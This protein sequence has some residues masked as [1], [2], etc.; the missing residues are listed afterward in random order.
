VKQ[1]P[2][3]NSL[4]SDVSAPDLMDFYPDD[5]IKEYPE[6]EIDPIKPPKVQTMKAAMYVTNNPIN[7][8]FKW[9]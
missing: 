7:N 2:R 8:Y 5:L 4:K 9:N 1:A 6:I 3:S